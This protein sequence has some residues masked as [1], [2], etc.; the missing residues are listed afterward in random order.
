MKIKFND[1]REYDVF[2]VTHQMDENDVPIDIVIYGTKENLEQIAKYAS[3]GVNIQECDWV[4]I[5]Q[6]GLWMHYADYIC[7][8]LYDI[9]TALYARLQPFT[10]IE[11]GKVQYIASVK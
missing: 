2:S 5:M 11:A 4:S 6:S 10:V 8:V 7:N 9:C 3:S 1:G